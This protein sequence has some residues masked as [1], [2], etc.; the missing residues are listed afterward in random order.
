M[1]TDIV[2]A[3]LFGWPAA[4]GSFCLISGCAA[5]ITICVTSAASASSVDGSVSV[6]KAGPYPA[7]E[8]V[9][10]DLVYSIKTCC[11]TLSQTKNV[12]AAGNDRT[13]RQSLVTEMSVF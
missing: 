10:H 12:N 1:E 2:G 9:F 7:S 3:G 5:D 11:E 13:D 4:G 6:R 8:V